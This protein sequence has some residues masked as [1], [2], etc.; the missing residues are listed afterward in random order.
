MAAWR[1]AGTYLEFCN[2]DPGCG[3]N[4]RG[5]PTSAEGN[6]QALIS[7]VIES[8]SS[9]D[10]QLAGAKASWALWW[11]GPIH[12]GGGRGHA[13]IDCAGNDQ[14]EALARIWRGEEGW[15]L[16]EIFNSM[17]EEKTAVDRATI[18]ITVDGRRSRVS[19]EGVTDSR[20]TPLTNPV[21]GDENEVRIVK[22]SGFI[23]R[24]GEIAQGE[25]FKVDLP[26]MSW[27]LSSRHAVFSTFDYTNA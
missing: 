27:D 1:I 6:C 10:V 8:G 14:Y 11:P 22:K 4:F 12:E 21:T 3:C 13:Y 5:F 26:E 19:I 16:Y 9:D 25:R 15:G 24:D 7:H 23:W 2:C 17:L 20:M 18:D